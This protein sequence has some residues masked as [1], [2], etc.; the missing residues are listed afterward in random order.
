MKSKI[1]PKL[2]SN[3]AA[4]YIDAFTES[5]ICPLTGEAEPK[6]LTQQEF[7][8]TEFATALPSRGCYCTIS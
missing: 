8:A 3:I 5:E 7:R 1:N 2:G 6:G 4:R